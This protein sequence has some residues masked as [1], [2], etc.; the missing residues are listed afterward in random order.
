M[1]ESDAEPS[2]AEMAT[3]EPAAAIASPMSIATV[4]QE[5]DSTEPKLAAQPAASTDELL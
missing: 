5:S 3:E 2:T 4:E 1:A